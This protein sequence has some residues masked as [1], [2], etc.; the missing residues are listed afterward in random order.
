MKRSVNGVRSLGLTMLA[1]SKSSKGG[2][3]LRGI[4]TKSLSPCRDNDII[5]IGRS[6]RT[7]MSL[8]FS[9]SNAAIGGGERF[10]RRLIKGQG[11]EPRWLVT[12]KLRSYAAAHC[13]IMP[14]VH[15]LN[16]IYANNRAEISHK[17]T[18]QQERAMRGFRSS[19]QAQR[20][21]ALHGL[22]QKLFRLGRQLLQAVNYRLLPTQA[23][24]VSQDV[25]CA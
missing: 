22:R 8:I 17:P 16:H 15:H 13:T 20:F 9:C 18:R 12:D 5:C 10:F 6:I 14:T 3:G 23:F 19:D 4:S 2:W 11:G 7:A 24:Q 25:V 21:L 1:D